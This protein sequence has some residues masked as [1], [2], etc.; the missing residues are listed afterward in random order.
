[1][2]EYA[3]LLEQARQS[4]AKTFFADEVH[5]RADAEL[6][7]KWVLRGEPAPVFTR[8]G[9][10]GLDQPEVRREGQLL[11]GG[12]LGDRRGGVDGVGREQQQRNVGSLP[13]TVAGEARRS[14]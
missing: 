9:F 12:V 7:G 13:G 11:F 4:N 2:A 1:M 5:F 6:W 8:A 14:A 3:A 10:G